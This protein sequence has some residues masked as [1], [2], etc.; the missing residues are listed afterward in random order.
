MSDNKLYHH[1]VK[2]Q[3]WGVRRYQNKDGSRTS[4]A[5]DRATKLN[6]RKTADELK[7]KRKARK[8][9]EEKTK[10]SN[11][12]DGSRVNRGKKRVVTALAVVGGVTIAS[13]LAAAAVGKLLIGEFVDATAGT[14]M[15]AYREDHP[16]VG[17]G[18]L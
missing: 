5:K 3:K 16:Y 9:A 10:H 15:R 7:A 4:L 11:A 12:R 6:A 13:K 17:K 2:G 8:L 1:G 18:L 14:F